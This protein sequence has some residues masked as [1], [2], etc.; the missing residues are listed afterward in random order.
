MA[1]KNK[2][3]DLDKLFKE[4][5]GK[6]R[7]EK[8]KKLLKVLISL[9]ALLVIAEV[10]LVGAIHW[11]KLSAHE[12]VCHSN[13]LIPKYYA[14]DSPSCAI[15]YSSNDWTCKEGYGKGEKVLDAETYA[16]FICSY[17]DCGVWYTTL[18]RLFENQAYRDCF[19]IS[20]EKDVAHIIADNYVHKTGF[21][22]KVKR[23]LGVQ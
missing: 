21:W 16:L 8:D 19:N 14:T 12:F 18:G 7:K 6:K 5:P 3:I 2:Q 9:L 1:K 4:N 22:E 20:E 10:A 11:N 13:T 17:Q 23:G 15:Y